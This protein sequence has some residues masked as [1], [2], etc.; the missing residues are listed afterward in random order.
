MPSHEDGPTIAAENDWNWALEAQTRIGRVRIWLWRESPRAAKD[1]WA[2]EDIRIRAKESADAVLVAI[3][4]ELIEIDVGTQLDLSQHKIEVKSRSRIE[5]GL[6][7]FPQESKARMDRFENNTD[8]FGLS[9]LK[10]EGVGRICCGRCA[11]ELV[12]GLDDAGTKWF[13]LP[14]ED[15]EEFVEYWVC[16]EDMKLKSGDDGSG[17]NGLRK[18]RRNEGFLGD[19]FLE[20]DL[21]WIDAIV[22]DKNKSKTVGWRRQSRA[23]NCRVSAGSL[24]SWPESLLISPP[25]RENAAHQ[26]RKRHYVECNQCCFTLGEV[27][28]SYA[29]ETI[30]SQEATSPANNHDENSNRCPSG[31]KR[32]WIKL[33]KRAI[34][35][36]NDCDSKYDKDNHRGFEVSLI[37][38]EISKLIE[39]NGFYKV[40]IKNLADTRAIGVGDSLDSGTAGDNQA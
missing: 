18:P 40:L 8:R 20:L 30:E 14:S 3:G 26:S 11:N 31:S 34:R 38:D 29:K 25:K 4:N 37:Q 35:L 16:H 19:W 21:N 5:I 1:Q 13:A 36:T 24:W 32:R 12:D 6:K 23:D 2:L 22:S 27:E 39:S 10:N 17:G 28:E 7:T 15:W 9:K 33:Y